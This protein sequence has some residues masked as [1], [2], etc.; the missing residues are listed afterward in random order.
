MH[1]LAA[2]I[3]NKRVEDLIE[4]HSFDKLKDKNPGVCP[5]YE[6]NRKCHDVEELNC[7]FCYCPKYDRSTPEGKCKIN[8]P[9]G[10]YV[11]TAEGKKLDCS[12]CT[13]PHIKEN[14]I[15][16]LENLFK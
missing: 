11:E 7:F 1:E 2:E 3:I 15:K 9:E 16:L 8:S 13:L 10:K 14:A 12:D 6:Q 4:E 5:C